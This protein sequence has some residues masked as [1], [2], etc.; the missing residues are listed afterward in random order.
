[1]KHI[2][3]ALSDIDIFHHL[4]NNM[5]ESSHSLIRA[6]ITNCCEGLETTVNLSLGTCIEFLHPPN[7]I[8]FMMLHTYKLS[9]LIDVKYVCLVYY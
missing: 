4:S 1:M 3:T 2:G 9:S 6:E 7:F 8:T 5:T